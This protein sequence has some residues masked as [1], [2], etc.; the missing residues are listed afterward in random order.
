MGCH[1]QILVLFARTGVSPH[2]AL[3]SVKVQI[4]NKCTVARIESSLEYLKRVRILGELSG[5]NSGQRFEV[6]S[7]PGAMRPLSGF[8][9]MISSRGWRP[10]QFYGLVTEY[11]GTWYVG[12]RFLSS[13][14]ATL[15]RPYVLQNHKPLFILL[16][17][18][19]SWGSFNTRKL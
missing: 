15:Y 9:A 11:Q 10:K 8:Q 4:I 3:L 17:R 7:Q 1:H 12:I 5:P 19:T 13:V 16:D 2:F 6:R 14:C 18:H